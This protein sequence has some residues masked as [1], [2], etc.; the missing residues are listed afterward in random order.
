VR[1]PSS[2]AK[3]AGRFVV[4]EGLDGAG[5]TTQARLLCEALR[6]EGRR[7]HSTAEP[8]AG[9]VG[10]L[11]RQI[12]TRRVAGPDGGF[13]PAALALLFAADR[14][15]HVAAE[16]GPKLRAGFDVISD[17][18]T[19]SSLAYQGV[20]TD[21]P[22]WVERVNARAAVPDVTIFLRVDAAVAFRRRK[23]ETVDR[24]IFEVGPFQRKVAA[25][26]DRAI[27][28]LRA[29]GQHI[30]EVDGEA[31][32]EAVAAAIRAEVEKLSRGR[33]APGG[34]ARGPGARKLR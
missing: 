27:R 10:A 15:D 20:T 16:I 19:L 6:A 18:F 3:R 21:D 1:T 13:D 33:V 28:A 12:L 17:R 5:T 30:V 32:V 4:L 7:V 2:G 11:V 29:R 34:R 8:S 9:P 23:A 31:P 14:L 26:Y 22:A 25:S 24:E